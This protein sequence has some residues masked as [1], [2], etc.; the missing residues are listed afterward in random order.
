MTF[1]KSF[2]GTDNWSLIAIWER[3]PLEADGHWAEHLYAGEWSRWQCCWVQSFYRVPTELHQ[4]WIQVLCLARLE[5]QN[6][7]GKPTGSLIL[8]DCKSSPLHKTAARNCQNA[9]TWDSLSLTLCW[10]GNVA[11]SSTFKFCNSIHLFPDG[12]VLQ[13]KSCHCQHSDLLLLRYA[14]NSWMKRQFGNTA[15][16]A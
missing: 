11:W 1:K 9:D 10:N 13:V 5:P 4:R 12:A 8:Q 2:W 6:V 16:K 7:C 3:L 15:A 14:L